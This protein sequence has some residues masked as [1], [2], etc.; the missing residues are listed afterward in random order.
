MHLT[1]RIF[2]P[3]LVNIYGCTL[4]SNTT[5]GP[6]VEI[7]SDVSIGEDCKISSHA[8][9]CSGVTIGNRV[10]IG[11]GVIFINDRKPES[12]NADGTKKTDKDWTLEKTIIEDDVSIGS[13]AIIMCGITLHKGCSVGAGAVVTRD[14]L[15]NQTVVG[16]P[17]R[18]L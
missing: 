12:C 15:S 10:F 11:H 7:Q 17:A 18:S 9:I 13:G 3:D 5:V 14:V 16:V 8:F 1:T 4:G 2:Y 6:F